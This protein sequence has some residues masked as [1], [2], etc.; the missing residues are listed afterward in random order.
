MVIKHLKEYVDLQIKLAQVFQDEFG[1]VKDKFLTAIPKEGEI[2]CEGSIWHFKKHGS[3]VIFIENTSKVKVDI[4]EMAI[5]ATLFDQWR[6]R[7][8]FGSLGKRGEKLISTFTGKKN[9]SLDENI[10]TCLSMLLSNGEIEKINNYYR[11]KS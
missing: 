4:H 11:L 8:Y 1:Q 2:S 9:I 6:V 5:E 7:T 10:K 3:G